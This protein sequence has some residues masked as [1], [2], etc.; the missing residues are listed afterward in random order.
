MEGDP[1]EGIYRA[2]IEDKD[3]M[4]MLGLTAL[5]LGVRTGIDI[6]ADQAGMVYRPAFRPGEPNGLSCSPTITD[7]PAFALPV[8]WGGTNS[9]AVLWRIEESDLATELVAGEDTSPQGKGRHISI[10][11]SGAMLFDEYIRALQATR[12]KWKK[13]TRS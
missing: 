11:P 2:M 3:G 6:V 12:S 4:P 8:E 7:L 10:G 13:I 5:K 1:G 9:K